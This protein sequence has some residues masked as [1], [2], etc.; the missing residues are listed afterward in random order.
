M[1]VHWH[2]R[3]VQLL[4]FTHFVDFWNIFNQIIWHFFTRFKRHVYLFTISISSPRSYCDN[5]I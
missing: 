4:E 5:D 1:I 3:G 2:K